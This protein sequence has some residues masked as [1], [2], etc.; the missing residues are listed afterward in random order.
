[1]PKGTDGAVAREAAAFAKFLTNDVNQLA[2]AKLAGAFPTST[3]A[4]ADPHFQRFEPMPARTTRRW[5]WARNGWTW[6]GRCTSP[7]C[8]ASNANKR[9]QDAVEAAIIGRK[10]VR[11]ALDD[12]AA[13]WNGRQARAAARPTQAAIRP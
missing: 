8:P 10:D 6:C 11:T 12:A 7:A 4:V 3:K 5:R 1:M 2:F 9:L 13:F